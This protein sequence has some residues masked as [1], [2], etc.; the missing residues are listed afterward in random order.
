MN[1]QDKIYESL[2]EVKGPAEHDAEVFQNE[3]GNAGPGETKR[4]DAAIKASNEAKK[5]RDRRIWAAA[6]KAVPQEQEKK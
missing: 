1:W 4:A 6:A 2:I 3:L 5:R